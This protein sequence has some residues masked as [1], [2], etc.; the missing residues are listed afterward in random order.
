ML[1]STH[2]GDANKYAKNFEETKLTDK[3]EKITGD[4]AR[5]AIANNIANAKAI[6]NGIK[7]DGSD[8]TK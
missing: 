3:I 6:A 5:E 8:T 1:S 7:C 4:V 2:I